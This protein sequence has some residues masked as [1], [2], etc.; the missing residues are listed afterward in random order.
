M[1]RLFRNQVVI[2]L[3]VIS[4]FVFSGIAS[5][6][7][8]PECKEVAKGNIPKAHLAKTLKALPSGIRIWDNEEAINAL[9]DS[10][11]KILWVDTRP[12]SFMKVGTLKSAVNLVCDLKGIPITGPDAANAITKDRLIKEM[13]VIDPNIQNVT[14]AFFCQGPECHRSY[15]AALRCVTDYGLSPSKVIWFRDGYPNLEKYIL[16]NPKLKKKINRYLRGDVTNQ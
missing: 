11:T 16:E 8:C 2:L 5:A 4:S 1:E 9:K 3:L 14:V 12:M 7:D 10:N 13:K 15:N 6:L